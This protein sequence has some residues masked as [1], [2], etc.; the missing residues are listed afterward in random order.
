[1][2]QIILPRSADCVVLLDIISHFT[3]YDTIRLCSVVLMQK[4]ILLSLGY[5]PGYL[6]GDTIK[7]KNKSHLWFDSDPKSQMLLISF[8]LPIHMLTTNFRHIIKI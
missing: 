6:R 7:S 3:I 2:L 8:R 5:F 4:I 1:M